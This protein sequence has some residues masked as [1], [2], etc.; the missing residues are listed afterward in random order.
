M[1]AIGLGHPGS[2]RDEEGSESDRGKPSFRTSTPAPSSR[3]RWR[4]RPLRKTHRWTPSAWQRLS[5]RG[6]RGV[7][8]RGE[9]KCPCRPMCDLVCVFAIGLTISGD[10]GSRST[11]HRRARWP[12]SVFCWWRGRKDTE[13]GMRF[14][15]GNPE[16]LLLCKIEPSVDLWRDAAYSAQ[17]PGTHTARPSMPARACFVAPS[18]RSEW[19]EFFWRARYLRREG[20]GVLCEIRVTGRF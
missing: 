19:R 7:Y 1:T 12:R 11:G 4:A 3:R 13:G 2:M 20:G 8:E 17:A 6:E 5:P 15:L 14:D 16:G 9:A 10:F 18:C